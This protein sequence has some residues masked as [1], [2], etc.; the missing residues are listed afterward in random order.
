MRRMRVHGA[1]AARPKY[2]FAERGSPYEITLMLADQLKKELI[3]IPQDVL[4]RSSAEALI[5][6]TVKRYTL[7]VPILDR[8]K[9]SEFEPVAVRMQVPQNSQYGIFGGPGPHFVDATAFRIKIP[10]TGDANLFR[11]S[12]TGY[13]NL[14]EGEAIDDAVI[15]THT[16]K[17]PDA[18]AVNREFNDRINRIETTLQFSRESV[19][20][21]NNGLMNL[22]KPAIEKRHATFQRNQS[23]TLGYQRAATPVENREAPATPAPQ[24]EARQ[25]ATKHDVFLSHASE[26]KDDIARPLYDALKAEGISVWFDEAV[27]KIGDSLSG[28]IDEGLARCGHG[29]VIISPNFLAKGWPKKELAGLVAREMAGGKTVILPI[30]HNI[31]HATLLAHSPTL[32]DKVAG[33]SSDGIPT[34]VKMIL[35]VIR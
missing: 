26:D 20:Q 3:A 22:V 32:A 23:M 4:M 10:F 13:G 30:W 6:D 33:K 27:L 5:D 25:A 1:S 31:D 7:N 35:D 8:N 11:Y 19:S 15:L 24:S 21:W 29:I 17:D 2:L 28:K 16:A 9:I 12:T 14:I 18:E 34:L